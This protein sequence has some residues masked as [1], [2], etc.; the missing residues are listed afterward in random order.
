MAPLKL[1]ICF[2]RNKEGKIEGGIEASAPT[3]AKISSVIFHEPVLKNMGL[4][5]CGRK[6]SQR[7]GCQW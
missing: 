3:C 5:A 7:E 6:M 2:I 4:C 1:P